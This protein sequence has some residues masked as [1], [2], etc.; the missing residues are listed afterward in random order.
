MWNDVIDLDEFYRSHLGKVALRMIRRRIREVWPDLHGMTV[1]G[2]GHAAP[3]LRLFQAEADRI[4]AV[5]P[6]QQ[7]V[8]PWPPGEP[9][10]VALAY[11]WALP[12]ADLSVD[13]LLLVHAVESSE[14]LREMM[15]EAWRVLKGNGKMLIVAPNRT[16]I[17]A[18]SERTPFG[19]GYPYTNGQ[20]RR[21]LRDCMFTP[22]DTTRALYMPP[23][24]R[25]LVLKSAPAIERIGDRLFQTFAGVLL[26]EATKQVYAATPGKA[27]ERRRLVVLPG[28]AKPAAEGGV[29]RERVD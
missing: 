23:V 22:G 16:G 11:E 6:A 9:G 4:M 28:G 8:I 17:W 7:G 2:L 21:L 15:R 13:R 29:R 14:Q 5:S 24:R 19:H 25:R 20:L 12:F 3:Y 18:R 27:V 10:Q 26:V 1:L